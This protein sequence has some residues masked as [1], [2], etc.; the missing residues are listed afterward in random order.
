MELAAL[1]DCGTGCT[2][3]LWNWLH[4]QT[5][6]L[7]ALSDCGTGCTVRLWNWLHWQTVELAALSDRGTGCTVR[8]WKESRHHGIM[9]TSCMC[10]Y[11]FLG[12]MSAYSGRD[13]ALAVKL[14]SVYPEA[15]TG[16]THQAWVMMFN[17]LNGNLTAVSEVP[18][19][20]CQTVELMDFCLYRAG[21]S[22]IVICN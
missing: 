18:L 8:L 14:V 19:M 16:A 22:S 10:H 1:S 21:L 6:E 11:R 5:V 9:S 7:A 4:C 15:K 2:V 13:E 20:H 12:V 3:R 17:P